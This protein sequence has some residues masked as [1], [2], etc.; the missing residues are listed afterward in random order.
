MPPLAR[1]AVLSDTHLSPAGTPDG[2]W[3][4]VTCRSV[5][6]ELLGAA[7]ADI[8]SSGLSQ[9]ILL[10]DV[11]DGGEPGVI[12]AALDTITGAGMRVWAVPGNHDASRSPDALAEAAAGRND[13]TVLGDQHQ[14]MGP[15]VV[16]VGHGLRSHDGGRTCEAIG[17]PDPAD[18]RGRLLLWASHY[19]VLSQEDRFRGAGLRYP[20]D[21]RNLSHVAERVGRFDGPVL[22]LHGHLHAPALDQAGPVL[23]IGVPAAV[24]WPNAWT[25]VTLEVTLDA[26]SAA[27]ALHRIPGSWPDPVAVTTLAQPIQNWAYAAGHWAQTPDSVS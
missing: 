18:R 24:E 25:E 22:V 9:V 14:E 7:V 6:R 3:N 1:F 17:V 26:V 23:Q 4:N 19:P 5:S 12:A 10:G 8:A 11:S 20:G 27:T 2:M 21:L 13:V 16:V 15:D